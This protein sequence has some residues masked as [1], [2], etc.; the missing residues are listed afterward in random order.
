MAPTHFD[1]LR[2]Y[3]SFSLSLERWAMHLKWTKRSLLRA[4]LIV[5]GVMVAAGWGVFITQEEV[6]PSFKYAIVLL[7]VGLWGA[8]EGS[9]VV[10]QNDR[11]RAIDAIEDAFD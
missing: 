6:K 11:Q 9:G 3:L 2:T 7:S 10:K 5:Y 4:I 8:C 1:G